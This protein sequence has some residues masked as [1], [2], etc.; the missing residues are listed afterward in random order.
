M[1]SALP[2]GDPAPSDGLLPASAAVGAA[3]RDF[4]VYL[5]VPFCR[6]RCGY[7]DF[8]TYTATELRGASQHDY[9][10]QAITEVQSAGRI[11]TQSGVPARQAATVFFGGGTPTLLPADDLVRM[12][13]AV[14]STWGIAP[15]AEVTTEANPDSVDA[16]YLGRLAES[17]FTRVSFGMQSAVPS[18]LATLERTHD[19]E[20]VPL[21]VQWAREA[22]LDVSLDLIYGTPGETLVDWRTSLEHAIRQAPT[23]VSAYSLIV[24]EGTKLARQIKR[25]E[26]APVDDD[27]QAEFYELADDLLSSA[28]YGWYEVSNWAT[29][30]AHRSRHNLAYWR[31]QDWWG[32]G[33]GAHSHIGGVRWWNVKHPSAYGDRIRAGDSPAAGRETLDAATQEVERVLLLTRIREG[34]PIDSLSPLRRHEVAGLIADELIDAKAAL[35]G[36]I[37]LTLRGRLLADA[38][39][40]RLLAD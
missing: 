1:G 18:V 15:G 39:V 8:N 25:G 31:S 33:P 5:H 22:G 40:R 38:V 26:L 35:F 13:E 12:L 34:I 20:R 3:Q 14:R 30:D 7:C 32:V 21:K 17:G 29:D 16:A 9:A 23:H 19:P 24:E 11:L 27:V 10:G 2:L 28:G 6:V 4:G 36:S 37:E